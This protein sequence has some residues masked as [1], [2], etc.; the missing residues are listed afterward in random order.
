MLAFIAVAVVRR[1]IVY[2][3]AAA[4]IGL[5][6]QF[7]AARAWR[8][9]AGGVAIANLLTL[10]RLGIVL[11]L[12]A[13]LSS[14]PRAG[15][16][17]LVVSLLVLDGVDGRVARA[18]SEVSKVGAS[19]DM[20]TDALTVMVLAFLLWHVESIGPWVLIAGLWRY[21]YAFVI[22][23]VPALGDSPPSR[24]HRWIFSCLMIAF[25]GAFVPWPPLPRTLAAIGTTLVSL[26]F[27]YSLARSRAFRG[28]ATG[29]DRP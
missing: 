23:L 24:I 29:S 15:F 6:V 25:A 21:G 11:G 13:L 17:A 22:A 4:A 2:V 7:V 26:S 14:L 19:F 28:K 1:E 5:G 12:P 3:T 16:V 9:D 20:E 10:V 27:V 8:N 18:R